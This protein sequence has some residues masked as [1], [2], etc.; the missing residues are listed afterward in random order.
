MVTKGYRKGVYDRVTEGTW[1]SIQAGTAH[2]GAYRSI[3]CSR[4]PCG[5]PPRNLTS[6]RQLDARANALIRRITRPR[7][8][9]LGRRRSTC[10]T[11]M[12]ID[13]FLRA[14]ESA[15]ES[16]EPNETRKKLLSGKPQ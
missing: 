1:E 6:E 5:S 7:I 16:V 8:A 10:Q 13:W 3:S 9:G 11:T 4:Q 2:T 12:L 15:N 14:G